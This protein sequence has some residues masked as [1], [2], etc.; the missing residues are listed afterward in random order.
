[1]G[2]LRYL[3]DERPADRSVAKHL[4]EGMA[5]VLQAAGL[6]AMDGPTLL[7]VRPSGDKAPAKG[8]T[9]CP[10]CHRRCALI[11]RQGPTSSITYCRGA[12]ERDHNGQLLCD[13]VVTMLT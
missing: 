12:A 13:Y 3:R 7:I 9:K 1:M 6:I 5:D 8:A 2:E 4:L 11:T 10:K